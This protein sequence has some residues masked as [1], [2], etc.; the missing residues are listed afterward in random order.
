MIS[1]ALAATE[2]I[3]Q[4]KSEI[5]ICFT[6]IKDALKIKHA[7]IEGDTNTPPNRQYHESVILFTL[8]VRT[9]N[10]YLSKG[11]VRPET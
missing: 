10:S 9:S 11:G 5:I 1:S 3:K 8:G 7:L 2:G 6:L 4:K